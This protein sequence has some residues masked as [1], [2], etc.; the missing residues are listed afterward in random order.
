M[1][2]TFSCSCT[3]ATASLRCV[4]YFESGQ[5]ALPCQ[6]PDVA[7]G[8]VVDVAA[9]RPS[10]DPVRAAR[11]ATLAL[12]VELFTTRPGLRILQVGRWNCFNA[13]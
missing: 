3:G 1:C 4:V 8:R 2:V 9:C 10:A 5:V 6:A 13:Q 7:V 11:C 12:D